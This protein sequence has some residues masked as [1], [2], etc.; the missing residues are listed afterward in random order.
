M[1]EC[2]GRDTV[3]PLQHSSPPL[4]CS[5]CHIHKVVPF[6]MDKLRNVKQSSQTCVNFIVKNMK[7]LYVQHVP[8][9]KNIDVLDLS[10][11]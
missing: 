1:A 5:T 11:F 3:L 7:I 4:Y 10:R 6:H 8:F 9:L 2:P